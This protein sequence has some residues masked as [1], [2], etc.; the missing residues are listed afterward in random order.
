MR[1][2][3]IIVCL[4]LVGMLTAAPNARNEDFWQHRYCEGMKIEE[5]LPS[6]GRVD[7]L[8]TEFAIEMD[9]VDHWA[10]AVGQSLYY[11]GATGRKPAIILICPSSEVHVEGLCRSDIYRLEYALKFVNAPI[12]L[13]ECFPDT[14]AKLDDCTR[15]QIQAPDKQLAPKD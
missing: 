14:D 10:E 6:G 1:K 5:H 13:W 15:P 11:A 8:S 3:L 2:P 7:C 9:W 12:E 4:L